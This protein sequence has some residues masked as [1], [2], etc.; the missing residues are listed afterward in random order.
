MRRG[1]SKARTFRNIH[2]NLEVENTYPRL[3]HIRL[4]EKIRTNRCSSYKRRVKKQRT[5][6]EIFGS[7]QV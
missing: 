2:V 7:N 1:K 4:E 3:E 6:K 5:R